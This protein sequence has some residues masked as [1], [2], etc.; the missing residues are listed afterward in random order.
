M[1]TRTRMDY[2]STV[3]DSL[4]SHIS[5]TNGVWGNPVPV[6]FSYVPY[7]RSCVDE[8]HPNHPYEGGPFDLRE[9]SVSYNDGDGK[10]GYEYTT[11]A[12]YNSTGYRGKVRCNVLANTVLPA[13]SSA[14]ASTFGAQAW[15]KYKP[16]KPVVSGGVFLAE[17]REMGP[18]AMM[19]QLMQFR[20]MYRNLSKSYGMMRNTKP[21][22]KLYLSYMFGWRPF[23]SDL[24]RWLDSIKKIDKDIA[25]LI[26][27]N[28][29]W[30][31]KG[32]TL[33]EN[34]ST[35]QVTSGA[36]MYPSPTQQIASFRRTKTITSDKCWFVGKFRYYIPELNDP[37][38]GKFNARRR[39]YDLEIGPEQVYQLLPYSWLIDWF[40]NLGNVIS[41][42]QSSVYD[43]LVAKYAYLMYTK[44]IRKE[45]QTN[46]T[47]YT[48]D[49]KGIRT[50][51]TANALANVDS[52]TKC[53]VAAT[54]FGFGLTGLDL[55]PYRLS[56]LSALGLSK[57]RF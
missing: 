14:Y 55:N 10:W 22:S 54:P 11:P 34:E 18:K 17:L 9:S 7:R 2:A 43:Q 4:G 44:R 27:Q 35:V 50:Y 37:K 24:R 30:Q 12:G 53:R 49:N 40:S 48:L 31:R 16:G 28:G 26:R 39:L 45:Y 56:I 1:A 36:S 33:F 8:V 52:T 23:L 25:Q 13:S 57:L 5:I 32:G 51:Y 38:W 6:S 42:L 21:A 47:T 46:Y 29:Q 15:N 20:Q 19:T 3:K 41:N